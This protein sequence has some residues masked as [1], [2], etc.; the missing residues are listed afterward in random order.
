MYI[1]VERWTSPTTIG[2]MDLKG[3]PHDGELYKIFASHV[4]PRFTFGEPN[5]FL[6]H[7]SGYP[8]EDDEVF[9]FGERGTMKANEVEDGVAE[10]GLTVAENFS[11]RALL[12]FGYRTGYLGG[13]MNIKRD[14]NWIIEHPIEVVDGITTARAGKGQRPEHL[15]LDWFTPQTVELL[16]GIVKVDDP[17]QVPPAMQMVRA[18]KR[19]ERNMRTKTS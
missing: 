19:R 3:L 10:A 11:V 13:A 6:D 5:L 18:R 14:D 17:K 2:M 4:D 8:F 9:D 15:H 16:R 7:A 1:H 12:R